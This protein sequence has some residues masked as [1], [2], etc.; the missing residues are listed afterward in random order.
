MSHYRIVA[1]TFWTGDTGRA[2][3][4]EGPLVQLMALYLI[5]CQSSRMCG[6]FY[7][8]LPLLAHEIGCPIE[9]ATRGLRGLQKAR[10]AFYD[11]PSEVVWIP[12]MA[13]WQVGK[14]IEPKPGKKG[15]KDTRLPALMAQLSEVRNSRFIR[16]FW[17]RYGKPYSLPP[18]PFEPP[19]SPPPAPLDGSS[20]SDQDQMSG[21]DI[22]SSEQKVFSSA[23]ASEPALRA[24]S[25]DE[26]EQ[27]ADAELSESERLAD[28]EDA[29]ASTTPAASRVTTTIAKRK[30]PA[31]KP[32]GPWTREACDDYVEFFPDSKPPGGAI[33]KGLKPFVEEHGWKDVV[34]PA[35]RRCL[36]QQKPMYAGPSIVSRF[37][38][39]FGHW[40][41]SRSSPTGSAVIDGTRLWLENNRREEQEK[42]E[43]GD[44]EPW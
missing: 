35:W 4:A 41:D 1:P 15:G 39:A 30:P 11:A 27:A 34:R 2:L 29:K 19:P 6:I 22:S 7:L 26:E 3:R 5:T 36:S 33:G 12:E 25:L 17:E 31:V 10:F 38:G 14:T 21:S 37:T 44:T 32:N 9:G 18:C 24:V 13:R 16:D 40:A 23:S 28:L 20:A 43:K 42:T 8:P